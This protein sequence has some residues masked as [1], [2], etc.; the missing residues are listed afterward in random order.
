MQPTNDNLI[1]SFKIT[2]RTISQLGGS[3]TVHLSM[4]RAR[5]L[6]FNLTQPRK[7]YTE[8]ESYS[9]DFDIDD[10]FG[11]MSPL[12]N[13]YVESEGTTIIIEIMN[14]GIPVSKHD[15]N[16]FTLSFFSDSK[17]QRPRT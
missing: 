13:T 12:I 5:C 4:E 3:S 15:F 16:A 2:T 1:T 7:L 11:F 10:I 8:E 6:H 9:A 14:N 17:E